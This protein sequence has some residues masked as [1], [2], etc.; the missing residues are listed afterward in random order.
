AL[1][2]K[3]A[4]DVEDRIHLARVDV[5]GDQV[6]DVVERASRGTQQ[7][8]DALEGSAGL[9]G[10]VAS[11]PELAG[12]EDEI[13]HAQ[14]R[15]GRQGV[16]PF[17]SGRTAADRLSFHQPPLPSLLARDSTAARTSGGHDGRR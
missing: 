12:D 3:P 9:F 13:A 6:D 4:R 7:L 10:N 16:E 2:E 1:A 17:E 11:A 5:K 15:R 14:R 8:V